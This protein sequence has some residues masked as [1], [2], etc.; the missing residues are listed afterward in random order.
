MVF[1]HVKDGAAMFRWWSETS[2]TTCL[3]DGTDCLQEDWQAC[4]PGKDML[5]QTVLPA[6]LCLQAAWSHPP[7]PP[8]VPPIPGFRGKVMV[9]MR[10]SYGL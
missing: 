6:R 9:S 2:T 1:H 4:A 8:L 7:G 5:T 3:D 10:Q